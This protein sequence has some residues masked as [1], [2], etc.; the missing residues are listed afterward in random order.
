VLSKEEQTHDKPA[1][2]KESLMP[3]DWS[4]NLERKYPRLIRAMQFVACLSQGEALACLRDYK[5]GYDYSSEAVNH[6]GGCRAVLE[7][8]S[9]EHI[10]N[11]VRFARMI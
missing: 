3:Y 10:R 2:V 5:A 8:A 1:G 6:F 4:E 9:R 7:R 11:V